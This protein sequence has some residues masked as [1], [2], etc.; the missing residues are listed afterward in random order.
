LMGG[1]IHVSS[2][3]GVGTTVAL[4]LPTVPAPDPA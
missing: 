4:D 1:R 2:E 3:K